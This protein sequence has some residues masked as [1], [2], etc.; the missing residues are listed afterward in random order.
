MTPAC[1]RPTAVP[2][3]RALNGRRPR[4]CGFS[5]SVWNMKRALAYGTVTASLTVEGFGV[6][7]IARADR[8]TIERRYQE[9]QQFIAGV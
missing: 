2:P 5:I 3:E 7:C 6:D 4:I 8:E 1:T 9:L